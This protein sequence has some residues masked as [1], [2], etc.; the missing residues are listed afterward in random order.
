[1]S[2]EL[3]AILD[4]RKTGRVIQDDRGRLEVIMASSLYEVN[5]ILRRSC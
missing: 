2:G 1:M 4:D 5:P 3:V